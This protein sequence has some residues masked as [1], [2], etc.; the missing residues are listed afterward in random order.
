MIWLILRVVAF[1][2]I[3]AGLAW[4]GDILLSTE[5]QLQLSWNGRDYP[6][7]TP[8]EAVI[9]AVAF[10]IAVWIV[11]KLVGLAIALLRFMLGDETA[12]TR[13]LGRSRERRGVEAA[14][15]A[16]VALAGGDVEAA[17]KH[18]RK[19]TRLLG[20]RD[21][22]R[23]TNAQVADAAGD[24]RRARAEYRALAKEPPTAMA[25][26]KGLLAQAER[27]GD[28]ERAK[29]LAQA[30][31]KMRPREAGNQTALFDLQVRDGDWTGARET[32]NAMTRSKT[33]PRDV[34]ARRGA[35]VDLE[36]ARQRQEQGDAAGAL[37]SAEASVKAAP[38]FVPAASFL[39][40]QHIAAGD[41]SR[42]ARL[43]REAWRRAPHPDLAEAFA[44]IEPAES[45][46]ERRKRFRDLLRANPGDHESRLTAA[47]LA[48]ADHDLTAA[49]KEL[50]DLPS[51]RPTHRTLALMA[52][53][54]K[55]EDAPESVVR[56]WLARAVTAPRGAHWRCSV[57]GAAP[58]QWSAVCPSCGAF[59]SLVWVE[60]GEPP[61]DLAPA[62]L[63]LIVEPDEEADKLDDEAAEEAVRESGA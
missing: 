5:G 39:A 59:D 32:L 18:A 38:D 4:L 48:M 19:A 62:M 23:L 41:G 47:E 49:R 51:T 20:A 40:R 31:Y 43:L 58:G 35:V 53:V 13:W 30:A 12:F 3:L 34:A 42:A 50:G 6:P 24:S 7:L 15:Q 9:A 27:D 54:E 33:L 8:L 26:V 25:G 57:C 60:G 17:K 36:I 46:A 21:L 29:K 52:A 14:G 45:P 22:T 55:G 37:K 1:I 10:I 11:I 61:E 44:A 28:T 2:A 56:G 63:P 16:Q